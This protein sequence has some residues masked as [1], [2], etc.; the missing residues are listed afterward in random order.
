M[1]Q[2]LV[3]FAMFCDTRAL[4]ISWQHLDHSILL[5]WSVYRFYVY[6][7]VRITLHHVDISLPY[8]DGFRKFKNSYIKSAH[9]SIS[10]D[11]GANADETL[12][13]GY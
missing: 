13:H 3:N 11:Y 5:L 6:F 9:Y 10:D 8:A 12:I 2:C 1:C 7:H 4:G